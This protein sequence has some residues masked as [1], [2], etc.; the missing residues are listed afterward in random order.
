[1]RRSLVWSRQD[2]G[3]NWRTGS[4]CW[5]RGSTPF[6][7]ARRQ[8]GELIDAITRARQLRVLHGEVSTVIDDLG[9]IARQFRARPPRARF[10]RSEMARPFGASARWTRFPRQSARV[11]ERWRRTSEPRTLAFASNRDAVLVALNRAV[12]LR[13]R[14]GDARA[15]VASQ[16]A[17]IRAQRLQL[18]QAPLWQVRRGTRSVSMWW[19]LKSRTAWR[20]LGDYFARDG[21]YLASLFVGIFALTGWLFR[22]GSRGRRIGAARLRA[23]V[24]R[25]AA[26]RA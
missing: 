24:C 15:L 21:I 9:L 5:R 17:R 2:S 14:V 12:A 19:P 8:Q 22:R 23:T 20:S 16:E 26:H 4:R 3:E 13:V 18:E 25:I 10:R 11:R 6:L 7:P 1:M